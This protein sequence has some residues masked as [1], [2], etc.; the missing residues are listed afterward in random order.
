MKTYK[1]INGQL[2]KIEEPIPSIAKNE[3]LV[4]V[5]AWSLN[6]RDLL[7]TEGIGH[8]KPTA[9]RIPVSDAAGEVIEIGSDT[10]NF[11][12][13]DRVTSLLLPNWSS[14]KL[15]PEKLAGSLGGA[16]RDGVLAEYVALPENALCKFPDYLSY[17]EAATLPIAALTA[18]NAVVEQS[19]LKL[20]DSILITGT[21]GVSLFSLQFAKLAGYNIIITSSSDEKLQSVKELGA[22]HTINYKTN[23]SWVEEVLK[24]TGGKG[25]DQVI[26]VV[27]GSHIDE[28]LKC[29]KSEGTVSMIGLIDGTKGT[30]DTGMI[31]S[32][33]A[34]IQ[35][36]ETG[37]TEM[38]KRMLAAMDLHQ[39][40]PIIYRTFPF[41]HVPEAFSLLK[42]G[43]H[44]GKICISMETK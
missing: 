23:K 11:E 10:S 39:L 44:F 34:T 4:K 36:V 31:M 26:D 5:H 37:S 6:Y 14:G 32:K 38:Y 17:E 20:G 40:H 21:G 7:V 28:S 35:G 30:I 12:I 13:G 27:G 41:D 29:I 22:H 15:S 24:I 43:G 42:K 25:V 16:A 1:I 18:W 8:W 3:I 9:P 2:T 19:T 33:A